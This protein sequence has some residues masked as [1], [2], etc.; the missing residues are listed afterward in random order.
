M[1]ITGGGNQR[2][3]SSGHLGE[4]RVGLRNSQRRRN[5]ITRGAGGRRPGN[6]SSANQTICANIKETANE[7]CQARRSRIPASPPC[8]N[9]SRLMPAPSAKAKKG[10][11]SGPPLVKKSR[12]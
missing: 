7:R 4:R 5:G 9:I 1:V 11:S 12:I 3:G 8:S 2:S 6:A 10:M